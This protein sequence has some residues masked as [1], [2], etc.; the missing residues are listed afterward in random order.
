[1]LSRDVPLNLCCFGVKLEFNGV[2]SSSVCLLVC[3]F[4]GRIGVYARWRVDRRLV[5]SYTGRIKFVGAC[6]HANVCPVT[7]LS[8]LVST[9]LP[10][11]SQLLLRPY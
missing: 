1:M 9:S 4:G 3:G 10:V 2:M 5:R 7:H 8:S 6:L 11:I